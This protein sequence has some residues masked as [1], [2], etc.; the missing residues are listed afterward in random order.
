[1][2]TV[3]RLTCLAVALVVGLVATRAAGRN[4]D[5]QILQTDVDELQ[6]QVHELKNDVERQTAMLERLLAL[7]GGASDTREQWAEFNANVESLRQEIRSLGGRFDG[8]T[9]R[10]N[11]LEGRLLVAAAP[12]AGSPSAQ[13]SPGASDDGETSQTLFNRAYAD[14]VNDDFELAV[15]EFRDFLQRYPGHELADRARYWIGMCFFNQKQYE[16]A[17]RE[18][19]ELLARNP[20]AP[21]APDAMYRKGMSLVELN[22]LGQAVLVLNELVDQ[23]PDTPAANQARERLRDLA[24]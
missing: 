19:D 14:Y 20:Q 24:Q 8:V 5:M 4:R 6:R 3:R 10:L 2:S 12:P 16:D 1:V 7:L 18:F 9:D 21:N 13:G 17:V 11:D 22:R 23:S 15:S